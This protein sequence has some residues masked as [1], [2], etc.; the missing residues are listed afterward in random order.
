MRKGAAGSCAPTLDQGSPRRFESVATM[1]T[2]A[3]KAASAGACRAVMQAHLC[4][5]PQRRR[6]PVGPC[7][8]NPMMGFK[9]SELAAHV[10]SLRLRSRHRR[11]DPRPHL[12]TSRC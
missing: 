2:R 1:R 3:L 5:H 12:A 9:P 4:R 6:W 8:V 10:A 11:P 7:A